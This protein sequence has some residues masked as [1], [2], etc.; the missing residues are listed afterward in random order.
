MGVQAS[1]FKSDLKVNVIQSARTY[2]K[3]SGATPE[4]AQRK[5]RPT[6]T[7]NTLGLVST[8]NDAA[9]SRAFLEQEDGIGVTTFGL[10][11]ASARTT[12]IA[13]V[14][15]RGREGLSSTDGHGLAQGRG[16]RGCREDIGCRA[17]F[18][19]GSML[20]MLIHIVKEVRA[21]GLAATSEPKTTR[22]TSLA[23][24]IFSA[25]VSAD[26]RSLGIQSRTRQFFYTRTTRCLLPNQK[27]R[28]F[29]WCKCPRE[30]PVPGGPC[31][32]PQTARVGA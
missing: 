17:A 2:A 14:G 25:L 11:V 20:T 31:S 21:Y 19:P 24:N 16:G 23:E 10:L 5:S 30:D 1:S 27:I 15:L 9:E 26:C 4:S 8:N 32:V 28:E 22:E 18:Q 7:V 3:V 29:L 13:S 6:K 12:V